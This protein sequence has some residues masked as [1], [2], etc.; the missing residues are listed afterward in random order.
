MKF[1]ISPTNESVLLAKLIVVTAIDVSAELIDA[2]AVRCFALAT[3]VR[4][5]DQRY[6]YCADMLLLLLLLLLLLI[7]PLLL[8][9][10]LILNYVAAVAVGAVGAVAV[11]AVGVAE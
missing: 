4:G 6:Y 1:F 11:G 8:L 5:I 10:L 7:N 2:V 3:A 9:L